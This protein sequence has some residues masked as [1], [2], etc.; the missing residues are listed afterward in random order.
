MRNRES[1]NYKTVH[2]LSLRW[3]GLVWAGL[4]NEPDR[5]A[6]ARTDRVDGAWAKPS[7]KKN[8]WAGLS[9]TQ[10]TSSQLAGAA[11]YGACI[12]PCTGTCAATT[13]APFRHSQASQ[14]PRTT[15]NALA[16]SVGTAP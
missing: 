3:P 16:V 9:W 7:R 8:G 11:Y 12:R 1:V 2:L 5:G 10:T 15:R 14:A 4:G 6:W 13:A